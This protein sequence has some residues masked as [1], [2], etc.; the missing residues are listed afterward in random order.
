MG[1]IEDNDGDK[2]GGGEAKSLTSC[3]LIGN[4]M[5][6]IIHFRVPSQE[7]VTDAGACASCPGAGFLGFALQKPSLLNLELVPLYLL[8]VCS[9]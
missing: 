1:G 9:R 2:A 5:K 8:Q 4:L 7:Q 6:T 3:E